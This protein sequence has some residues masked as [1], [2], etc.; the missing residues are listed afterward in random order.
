M[1]LNQKYGRPRPVR[2]DDVQI[3]NLMK[4][5]RIVKSVNA[6]KAFF[7]LFF[8]FLTD[9]IRNQMMPLIGHSGFRW[10]H[11]NEM[12]ACVLCVYSKQTR[13]TNFS[14]FYLQ[15]IFG[16]TET[17]STTVFYKSRRRDLLLKIYSEKNCTNGGH[18]TRYRYQ[19]NPRMHSFCCVVFTLYTNSTPKTYNVPYRIHLA[20]ARWF[21]QPLS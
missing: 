15:Q 17:T 8:F 10:L 6:Q 7:D 2:D 13:I 20:I 5:L 16:L 9:F 14:R 11:R 3:K 21:L 12:C 1:S 19:F 18:S 4:V